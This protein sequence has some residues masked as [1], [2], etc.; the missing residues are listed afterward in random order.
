MTLYY[1][2]YAVQVLAACGALAYAYQ[3]YARRLL[4]D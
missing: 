1:I 3:W 2:A 4:N